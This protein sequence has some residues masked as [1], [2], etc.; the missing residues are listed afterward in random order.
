MLEINSPSY[1]I[2]CEDLHAL[3]RSSNS[4]KEDGPFISNMVLLLFS[5]ILPT[6]G[7]SPS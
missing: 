7:R 5:L 3:G 6:L 4:I 1:F 2:L